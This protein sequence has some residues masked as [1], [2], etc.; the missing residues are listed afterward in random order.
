ML[1]QSP[2]THVGV[3]FTPVYLFATP[4]GS[5]GAAPRLVCASETRRFEPCNPG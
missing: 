5:S 3:G 4:L 1:E 2:Q